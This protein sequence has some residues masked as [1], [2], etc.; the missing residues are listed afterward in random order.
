[1]ASP[2]FIAGPAPRG[3]AADVGFVLAVAGYDLDLPAENAAVSI[4][5]RH[6]SGD[7]KARIAILGIERR[8]SVR[9]P[10]FNGRIG[11]SARL[12]QKRAVARHSGI[13][14]PSV[15]TFHCLRFSPDVI[16]LPSPTGRY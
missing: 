8:Q 15:R 2:L 9:T 1:M 5:D 3:H 6:P 14:T 10:S 16:H 11:L 7:Y 12:V 4:I 13:E